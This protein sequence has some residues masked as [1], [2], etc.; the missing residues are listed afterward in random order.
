MLFSWFFPLFIV[1][2]I[3]TSYYSRA[4][5]R[6]RSGRSLFGLADVDV[7]VK[8]LEEDVCP[9]ASDP[10]RRPFLE[11]DPRSPG[12]PCRVGA[13]FALFYGDV[14]VAVDHRLAGLHPDRQ[15]NVGGEGHVDLAVDGSEGQGNARVDAQESDAYVPVDGVDVGRPRQAVELNTAVGVVDLHV[16]GQSVDDDIAV[17]KHTQ[18]ERE[19]GRH[20]DV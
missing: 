16:S 18:F 3:F 2:R 7:A 17:V 11:G 8:A 6:L 14:E 19:P 13:A 9:P 20:R 4:G 10:A 12:F 5:K 1:L 15:V